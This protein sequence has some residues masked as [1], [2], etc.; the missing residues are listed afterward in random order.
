MNSV[1]GW[2]VQHLPVSTATMLAAYG[3]GIQEIV[4]RD[5]AGRGPCSVHDLSD[6]LGLPHENVR[7]ALYRLVSK[8]AVKC[9]LRVPSPV[10]GALPRVVWAACDRN[11]PILPQMTTA[12]APW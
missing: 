10:G 7:N 8:S 1:F 5:L 11:G 4:W 9:H 6:R 12:T 2:M 3:V